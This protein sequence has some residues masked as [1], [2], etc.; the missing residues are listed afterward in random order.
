MRNEVQ[1]L[2]MS[3]RILRPGD[4]LVVTVLSGGYHI[5]PTKGT[6]YELE[7]VE[8]FFLKIAHV[9]NLKRIWDMGVNIAP[10]GSSNHAFLGDTGHGTG[11]DVL[12]V[13][14]DPW[15]IYHFSIAP[16][17][18]K[19]RIYPMVFNEEVSGWEY[20]I[21]G[22][23]DPVAGDNY[24]Y[25]DGRE[26]NCYLDPTI[27]LE[28]VAWHS[29]QET[30][31]WYYGF[32]NDDVVQIR[33]VLNI[34]GAAYSVHPIMDKKIQEKL[35]RGIHGYERLLIPIGSTTKRNTIHMPAEWRNCGASML[36]K[37]DYYRE[38]IEGVR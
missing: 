15:L 27:H 4:N 31:P 34:R 2:H 24:G 32:Y 10:A 6:K 28:G 37:K 36:V 17:Q 8:A 3:E 13:R 14:N 20:L 33:P 18:D 22:Q 1:T 12:R 29:D 21:S 30:T 16:L 35:L 23:P 9:G 25:I 7:W 26:I 5:E 11:N 19:L 38:I